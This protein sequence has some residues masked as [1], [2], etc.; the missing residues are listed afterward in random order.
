[1]K[2]KYRVKIRWLTTL[3]LPKVLEIER[4][5]FP[6]PWRRKIFEFI[7]KQED[8]YLTV[9]ERNSQVVGYIITVI[10][11]KVDWTNLRRVKIGHIINLAVEGKQRRRG[12]GSMLVNH[13]LKELR[14][15]T[16]EKVYLEV[17]ESNIAAQKLYSTF[18]FKVEKRIRMY[19]Q[20]ME[21]AYMMSKILE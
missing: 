2:N 11:N 12:I 18:N 9:A 21:D 17:N 19:Y 10:E 8:S 14:K 4:D 1:M 13:I 5:S 16:V 7:L 3:D 15:R 6:E 20:N